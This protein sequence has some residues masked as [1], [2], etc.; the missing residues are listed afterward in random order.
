MKYVIKI[1]CVCVIFIPVKFWYEDKYHE[2]MSMGMTFMVALI[3]F[4]VAGG[5][6]LM[7]KNK[8]NNSGNNQDGTKQ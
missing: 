8:Q 7:I 5:V 6:E 1:I 2:S 3:A 4:G